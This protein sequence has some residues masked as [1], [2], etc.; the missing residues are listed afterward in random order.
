[1]LTPFVIFASIAVSNPNEV[2]FKLS[3][4]N[5][6]LNEGKEEQA[7][8][9]LDSVH[10]YSYQPLKKF[11][12]I[13]QA[14]AALRK[15]SPDLALKLLKNSQNPNQPWREGAKY[16]EAWGWLQKG[17][18]ENALELLQ[19]EGQSPEL[20]LLKAKLY[21]ALE[22]PDEGLLA[23]D[24]LLPENEGDLTEVV[25][26]KALLLREKG[27]TDEAINIL[28]DVNNENVKGFYADYILLT[29]GKLYFEQH[30]Y[31]EAQT[32]WN[33]LL[34]KFSRSPFRPDAL[35]W[36]ARIQENENGDPAEVGRIHRDIALKYPDFTYADE[37]HFNQYSFKDYL[38]G[39]KEA[40]LH[41][42]RF[43]TLYPT[44][45]L[46]IVAY[47]LIGLDKQQ[48]RRSPEGKSIRKKNIK[49][50]IH[51]F[52]LAQ[53]SYESL[54]P[55]EAYY[56][57]VKNQA[58]LERGGLYVKVSEDSN[59]PKK[60]V[61]LRYAVDLLK[62]LLK[63]DRETSTLAALQLAA[64]FKVQGELEEAKLTVSKEL[65]KW[66]GEAGALVAS[67]HTI[68][69]EIFNEQRDF[70]TAW[71]HYVKAEEAGQDKFLNH[72]QEL[73][74]WIRQALCYQEM[75]QYDQ[76]MLL[77]SQAINRNVVSSQRV[78][79]MYLR[80]EVYR[81]QGREELAKKQ[82]EAVALKGGEW[83]QLAR[84]KLEEEK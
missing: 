31:Q 34:Q 23:L 70:E 67:M 16:S 24:R 26:V 3:E 37:M 56:R 9:L 45:P 80:A 10:F 29:L 40:V 13:L 48:E 39:D 6:L 21:L 33:A 5:R 12:E 43:A 60:D 58:A 82:W 64:I 65:K 1:M 47:Y 22:K 78:R 17:N 83:G 51:S 68:Q 28:Q 53:E 11:Q 30:R 42:D 4:G 18:R 55:E 81:K 2:V 74:L 8:A 72:D 71:H 27:R 49:E 77:F 54:K 41:L 20:Q 62:P 84:K 44:S 38:Q 35:Y 52:E 57:Q 36:L 69:G 32:Q 63:E 73:D 46:K 19:D 15:N 14:R 66:D 61:Y 50:A 7:V 75:E 79:A 76:A 59:G 25:L